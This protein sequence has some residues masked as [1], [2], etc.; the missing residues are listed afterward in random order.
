MTMSDVLYRTLH[1]WTFY[2]KTLPEKVALWNERQRED[3]E[4]H[5]ARLCDAFALHPAFCDAMAEDYV[6]ARHAG[7]EEPSWNIEVF[8]QLTQTIQTIEATGD[9]ALLQ[10]AHDVI[11][12][13]TP[14]EHVLL[15]RVLHHL[16]PKQVQTMPILQA[17]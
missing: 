12:Q 9:L 4:D 1:P 11:D 14:A 15:L 2:A 17:Q 8:E 16:F 10:G 3:W 6:R 5:A 7:K 13:L